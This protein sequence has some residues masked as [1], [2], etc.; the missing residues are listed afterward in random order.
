MYEQF[1]SGYTQE[2]V[3]EMQSHRELQLDGIE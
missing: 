3:L 2:Q 1:S